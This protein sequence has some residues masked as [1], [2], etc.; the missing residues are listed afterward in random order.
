MWNVKTIVLRF[1]REE[2]GLTILEY[3]IGAAL[4]VTVLIA[5]GFW[6]SLVDKMND[7]SSSI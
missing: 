5:T 2:E 1:L 7:I 6:S 4:I 3:V